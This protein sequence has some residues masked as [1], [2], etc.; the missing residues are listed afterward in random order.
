MPVCTGEALG[1]KVTESERFM[2]KVEPGVDG[3]WR[4]TGAIHGA[5]G[6]ASFTAAGRRATYAHR[7]AYEHYV[8]PI[9]AGHVIDHDCHN[10]SLTCPGGRE[11]PHR[12]CANPAHLSA[13]LQRDNVRNAVDRISACRNGH[14][15]TAENVYVDRRGWRHC[16]PCQRARE[17]KTLR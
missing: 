11:C 2:A 14:P 1:A 5:S 17:R 7:W 13:V 8:G 16:R 6:Y 15:R 10:A 3:C 12:Q 4:W 9:P